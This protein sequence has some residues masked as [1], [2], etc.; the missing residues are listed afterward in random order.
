MA[1]RLASRIPRTGTRTWY[2]YDATQG[3]PGSARQPL[4]DAGHAVA[5]G[6]LDPYGTPEGTALPVPFGYTGRLID[7]ATGGQF[8]TRHAGTRRGGAAR[9]KGRCWTWTR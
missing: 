7:P 1:D 4:N 3:V 6:E 8:S 9:P 5:N 2:G